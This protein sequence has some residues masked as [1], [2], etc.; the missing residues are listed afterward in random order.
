MWK[1]NFDPVYREIE[2]DGFDENANI[3]DVGCNMGI[4]I[5]GMDNNGYKNIKGYD[6]NRLSVE[7][8]KDKYKNIA[9]N[10]IRDA[11]KDL[12][13]NEYDVILL[14]D[15]L[16]YVSRPEKLLENVFDALKSDGVAY[17]NNISIENDHF[18]Y[19]PRGWPA[20]GNGEIV[21]L[22]SRQGLTN[23]LT[24]IGFTYEDY[25][26]WAEEQRNEMDFLK[27]RKTA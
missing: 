13:K 15:V 17:L 7:N 24:E 1:N 12:G 3:L 26:M 25:G 18:K 14:S 2:N 10:I 5:Q 23:T 27:L 22:Y 8:G 11:T 21:T 19:D 20:I 4:F 9:E 16:P 6:I